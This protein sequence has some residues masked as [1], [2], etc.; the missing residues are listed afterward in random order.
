MTNAYGCAA[1]EYARSA[2]PDG[3]APSEWI[4][5]EVF[6]VSHREYSTGFYFGTEPGQVYENGGYVREY[7]VAAIVTGWS[8][9]VLTVSQRNRF[10][11]GDELEVLQ[12][13]MQPFALTAAD[14]TDGD[15]LLIDCAPHPTMTVRMPCEQPLPPGAILRRRK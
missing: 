4:L 11:S 2:D 13:R 12:P 5:D 15:G 1:D 3:F 6:K 9:G 8:D 10:C 14:M 7:E